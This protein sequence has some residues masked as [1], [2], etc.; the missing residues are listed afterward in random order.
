MKYQVGDKV[1]LLHSKEEGQVVEI[2]S[3][4][5][6]LVE[7]GGVS[8]PV[9]NDQIDFPYFYMFSQ[10]KTPEKKKE[11]QHIDSIR[12]DKSYTKFKVGNGV[13]LTFLPVF[14][15]EIMDEDLV[16]RFKVYLINQTD[17]SYRFTYSLLFSGVSEFELTNEL[18]PLSDFYL[19]DIPFED[20]NDGP[21]LEFEFSLLEKD[22]KKAP[23]LKVD[24]R[25]KAKQ[26]FQRIEEMKMKNEPTFSHLLFENYPDRTPDL[27]PEYSSQPGYLY[28]PGKQGP[29]LEPARSVIDLH[30]EKLS[31]DWS[32]LSNYEILSI[33]L[34]TFEKYYALAVAHYQPN[35]IVVH[36]LGT[37]KLK[38]EIH[39]ILKMKPEVKSFINRYHP[40]FGY[41][42]TE[43]YFQY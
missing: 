15:K 19:H 28:H 31:D 3:D 43:I 6:V 10:K 11:K 22:K 4:E 30:I 32:K 37:G 1:L 17:S 39:E 40:N 38:E 9:Y 42:A 5:M 14:D 12:K 41:G 18:L 21:R 35:L 33:Q 16:E 25:L 2:I 27:R 7:V 29:V 20:M 24:F 26:L 23:Q 13:W 34:G 8:F 36:G